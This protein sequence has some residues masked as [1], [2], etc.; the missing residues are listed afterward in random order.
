MEVFSHFLHLFHAYVYPTT[1][2]CC[3]SEVF[4]TCISR[5]ESLF[6]TVLPKGTFLF[7]F[8]SAFHLVYRFRVEKLDLVGFLEPR[9]LQC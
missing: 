5:L 7:L 9:T 4:C 2:V 8:P 3:S 1:F 6:L